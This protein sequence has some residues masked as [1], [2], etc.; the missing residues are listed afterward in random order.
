MSIKDQ[1]RVNPF[2]RFLRGFL[3]RFQKF[4]QD[5]FDSIIANISKRNISHVLDVGANVGQ[6][7]VDLY[8]AG[9]EGILISYEP[10]SRAFKKLNDLTLRYDKWTAI[11]LGMGDATEL[12]ILNISANA[13]LSSS[14]L[15]IG[16]V[17]LENFPKSKTISQEEVRMSTVDRQIEILALDPAKIMLKIDVQ[18]YEGQVLRG[19]STF[20]S[21]IPLC[22]L[23]VSLT[24]LY[25]GESDLLALINFLADAGHEIIDINR[26]VVAKDGT[27]LQVDILTQLN[28]KNARVV[29]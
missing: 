14:I 17:H 26:G 13:G 22:Y 6:F 25:V 5:P 1:L 12:A 19:A 10:A 29:E 8:N 15:E 2:A 28:F 4:N 16:K 7:G 18:G 21:R 24:P 3:N 9:F 11:N 27:L 23:E 20:L